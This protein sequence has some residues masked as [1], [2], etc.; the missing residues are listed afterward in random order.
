MA[1]AENLQ[2]ARFKIQS[3]NT[4]ATALEYGL[5]SFKALSRGRA[6]CGHIFEQTALI[7]SINQRRGRVENMEE[8]SAQQSVITATVPMERMFGYATELR[9]NTQGR[10]SFSMAFKEYDTE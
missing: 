7:G 2:I 4:L 8:R 3:A 5:D 6:D 1:A 10:G 9:S